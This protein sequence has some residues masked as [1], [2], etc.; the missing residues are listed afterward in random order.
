M[1][2]ATKA[3][4][5]TNGGTEWNYILWLIIK[6]PINLP[7]R[8]TVVYLPLMD[9]GYAFVLSNIEREKP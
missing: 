9:G 8:L 7:H 6:S 3:P 2:K 5:I 1:R 4:E